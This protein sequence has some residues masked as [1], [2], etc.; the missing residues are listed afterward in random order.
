MNSSNVRTV[1]FHPAVAGS[2]PYF[3]SLKKLHTQNLVQSLSCTDAA[4]LNHCDS[5]PTPFT[6]SMNKIEARL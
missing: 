6:E 2:N 3:E 4:E 5:V 1:D